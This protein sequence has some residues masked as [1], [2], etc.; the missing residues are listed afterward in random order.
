MLLSSENAETMES[1]ST[2]ETQQNPE[3]FPE[4][5]DPWKSP[6]WGSTQSLNAL[7]CHWMKPSINLPETSA[8]ALQ[9]VRANPLLYLSAQILLQ[10]LN[11]EL[12]PERTVS[13]LSVL[14]SPSKCW[15]NC[16]WGANELLMKCQW[17]YL[18]QVGT[19]SPPGLRVISPNGD[20]QCTKQCCRLAKQLACSKLKWLSQMLITEWSKRGGLLSPL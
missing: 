3:S 13:P 20:T 6:P 10:T 9:Y 15:W 8:K 12:L 11:P 18:A 16:Y 19:R 4:M 14:C 2:Q 1:N 7:R 17:K 5:V